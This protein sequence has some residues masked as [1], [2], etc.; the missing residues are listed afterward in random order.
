MAGMFDD[1]IPGQSAQP[2][3]A[4]GGMFDDLIPAAP[5]SRN[6]LQRAIGMQSQGEWLKENPAPTMKEM[7]GIGL[8][9][10][11]PGFSENAAG[12]ARNIADAATFGNWDRLLAAGKGGPVVAPDYTQAQAKL[13]RGDVV[14][15][16]N[17]TNEALAAAKPTAGEYP[18][19]D[20]ALAGERAKTA[21]WAQENPVGALE[22]GAIGGILPGGAVA[23]AGGAALRAL[24][25]AP[26]LIGKTVLGG[27]GGAGFGAAS[28]A[29][30][31]DTGW[32]DA[33]NAAQ[34]GLTEGPTIAGVTIPNY[35]IGAAAPVVGKA[36]GAAAG[37]L[38]PY[39][40]K[41][42]PGMGRAATAV[43]Q[44]ALPFDTPGRLAQLG[45]EGTL[46]DTGPGALAVTRGVVQR[47]MG[48]PLQATIEQTLKDRADQAPARLQ[49]AIHNLAGVPQDPDMVAKAIRDYGKSVT[50]P[51][52]QGL[53]GGNPPRINVKPILQDI[54]AQLPNA[55][56][57]VK[58]A[59]NFIYGELTDPIQGGGVLPKTSAQAVHNAK[60]ELGDK[61]NFDDE[62]PKGSVANGVL[63]N[64]YGKLSDALG[65]QVPGYRDATAE[66]KKYFDW[67]DALKSGTEVLG[68]KEAWPDTFRSAF[69]AMDPGAQ[70][71]VRKG[72]AA[73]IG[74]AVGAGGTNAKD[75]PQLSKLVGGDLDWNRA[76]MTTAFGPEATQNLVNR[77]GT[78]QTFANTQS[79]ISGGSRTA[80]TLAAERALANAELP[81]L[82][83]IPLSASPTGLAIRGLQNIGSGIY[84]ALRGMHREGMTNQ[85]GNAFIAPASPARD[86]LVRALMAGK[87]AAQNVGNAVSRTIANPALI[88]ALLSPSA[89]RSR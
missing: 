56:S 34:K 84:D 65:D 47:S 31:T 52:Y 35:A 57:S 67:I 41:A 50:D 83:Q 36:L 79:G 61:A 2:A 21:Q 9:P 59:L 3:P 30:H 4:S 87:G 72:M 58:K 16:M 29:G 76:N 68:S 71:F 85:L 22:A 55:S 89:P 54:Q 26:S 77:V 42:A 66:A 86:A 39:F 45:P 20:T 13:K 15:A 24:G 69:N 6:W 63:K 11:D 19:Y 7:L 5:D 33:W 25:V 32:A 70:E 62:M 64:F 88:S 53:W 73:S 14:G 78:E 12:A 80:P 49:D 18:D 1:L 82:G 51:M 75:L 8:A 10:G 48:T 74:K 44:D 46:T 37:F 27:A 28:E 17:A 40:Q 43:A 81:S 60:V 23:K 38:T